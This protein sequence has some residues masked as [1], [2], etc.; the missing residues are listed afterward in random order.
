[1]YLFLAWCLLI[2]WTRKFICDGQPNAQT[3]GIPSSYPQGGLESHGAQ[4]LYLLESDKAQATKKSL[5]RCQ[6]HIRTQGHL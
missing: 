4:P 2:N 6:D 3:M 1:M 5:S